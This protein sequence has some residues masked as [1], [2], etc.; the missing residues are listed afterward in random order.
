[1]RESL[2][3]VEIPALAGMTKKIDVVLNKMQQVLDIKGDAFLES[4]LSY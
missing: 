4:R 3:G 1:M 2:P